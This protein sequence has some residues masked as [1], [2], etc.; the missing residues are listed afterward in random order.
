[1]LGKMQAIIVNLNANACTGKQGIADAY[2][3]Q[4]LAAEKLGIEPY[5]VGVAST[6][7]IGEIMK[8]DPVKKE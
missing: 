2:E 4:A 6:G 8:M 3:M 1:M 7:V 5:L